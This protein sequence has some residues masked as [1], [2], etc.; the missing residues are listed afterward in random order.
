MVSPSI[1]DLGGLR[2]GSAMTA[3]SGSN[4]VEWRVVAMWDEMRQGR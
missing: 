4:D 1:D 3:N 2:T